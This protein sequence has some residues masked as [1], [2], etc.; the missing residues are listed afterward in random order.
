M[1]NF[2]HAHTISCFKRCGGEAVVTSACSGR[3]GLGAYAVIT[4]S[5]L[6]AGTAGVFLSG[7]DPLMPGIVQTWS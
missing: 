7:P 5:L 1:W 2:R 4:V 6:L 3:S